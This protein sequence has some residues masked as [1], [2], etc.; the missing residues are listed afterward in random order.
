MNPEA[1]GFFSIGIIFTIIVIS[2]A[3]TQKITKEEY[4]SVIVTI[5]CTLFTIGVLIMLHQH[6]GLE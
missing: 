2:F 4:I 3:I 1:F 5:L 6:L